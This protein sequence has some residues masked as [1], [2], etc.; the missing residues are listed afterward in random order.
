MHKQRAL[1]VLSF[2]AAVLAGCQGPGWMRGEAS[3]DDSILTRTASAA[4]LEAAQAFVMTDNDEAFLSKVKLIE[5]ARRSIDLAYYIFSDDYSSSYL[6]QA[7]IEAARRGVSVRLLVDYGTNYKRLDLYSMME[8]LGNEGRGSL[9]V[10]LY[11]RPTRNIV[12]DAVYI[13]MGCGKQ[14]AARRPAGECSKEKF[15]TLEQ[16]FAQEAIEGRPAAARNISNL[17]AGNSG[18]FLSGLY[19][20]RPDIMAT[21]VQQGEGIDFTKI[22]Q[23]ASSTTAQDKQNLKRLA[24][25]YWESKTGPAYQRLYSQAQLYLALSHYGKKLDPIYDTFTSLAPVDKELSEEERQDWDHLSDF[26]HHKLILVDGMKLQMGGRNVED[27]YHMGPNPLTQK[28]VFMDTDVHAELVRGGD[29]MSRA[30]DSLWNFDTMVASLAEVRQHAPNE[31]L[32]NLDAYKQAEQVCAVRAK[33]SA[34]PECFDREFAS[35]A[36]DLQQRIAAHAA[37]MQ[38]KA[39]RYRTDYL[40]KIPAAGGPSFKVDQGA[41]LAYLENLPFDKSLPPGERR[42]TYGAPVGEEVRSGK[43]IHEVWL[44]SF[45]DV[46]RAASKE[47]PKQIILHN[48]YFYPAANFTYEL[49]RMVNG[50]VDCSNVTVTVLTN[51]IQTTDLN[52][53][54]LA[55]RHALKAFTE[56]Y[57]QNRDKPK[58]AK[59]EYYEYRARQGQA[60]LSLHTKV[61]VLGDDVMIGS[62]NADVRSYMMDSNNAL[63]IRRAPSFNK[64]YSAFVRKILADP[65]RAQQLNDY[66]ASTPRE[67]MMK[68]DVATFRQLLVK[69]HAERHLDERQRAELEARFAEMLDDAYKLT[70]ESISPDNSASARRQRQNLFNELF[71]PI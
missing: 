9:R 71:K 37:A 58:R 25:T 15:A 39:N 64:E 32:A 16:L 42:R 53:V 35:H 67:V 17:N 52:I 13:T 31:L 1:S 4:P 28:Y 45:E 56:F 59:F 27:S 6:T 70:K 65:Q 55:A 7:L 23:S 29:A 63:F 61:S 46:C 33:V 10:R 2:L 12:Q 62:A 14:A 44:R 36:K 20:K 43:Y 11:N 49:S 48:A 24:K 8:K 19:A 26:L 3:I 41:L 22:G 69:Y 50:E 66:F 21:A 51:S 60:N 47:S 18:L 57:Q 68:E 54:N 30:F 38:E 40:P 34:T 5:G